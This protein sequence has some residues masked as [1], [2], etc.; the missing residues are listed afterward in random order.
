MLQCT[1]LLGPEGDAAATL[2]L[3]G[4]MPF[5][6]RV[7][8]VSLAPHVASLFNEGVWHKDTGTWSGLEV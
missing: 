7:A 3:G 5:S 2:R 8:G 4:H 6:R 1:T